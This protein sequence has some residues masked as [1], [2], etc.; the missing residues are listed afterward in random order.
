M[1]SAYFVIMVKKIFVVSSREAINH[2]KSFIRNCKDDE[3]IEYYPWW[4]HFR[5]GHTTIE[6]LE[7]FKRRLD[8]ALVILTPDIKATIRSHRKLI[9]N[10]N[11]LFEYGF[12]L[13]RFNRKH[14]AV[15]KYGDVFLPSDLAGV[16]PISGSSEYTTRPKRITKRTKEEFFRWLEGFKEKKVQSPRNKPLV[17]RATNKAEATTVSARESR[18]KL[19][20]D[21][22]DAVDLEVIEPIDTSTV[23]RYRLES[24]ASE[25]TYTF[26]FHFRTSESEQGWVGVTSRNS[27]TYETAGERSEAESKEMRP[28]MDIDVL[29]VIQRR[30]PELKGTPVIIDRLRLRGDHENRPGRIQVTVWLYPKQK[31]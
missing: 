23:L 4:E 18:F 29:S 8:G 16:I 7:R 27:A 21:D 2:A 24:I 31:A 20:A 17:N 9:P 30:W 3:H 22:F 13:S 6:E 5:P 26:Y 11:V 25:Q 15:V 12:F 1:M 19:Q 10:L 28:R 14:V